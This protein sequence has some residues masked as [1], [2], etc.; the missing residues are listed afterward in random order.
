MTIVDV[1]AETAE[2]V[3]KIA[4]SAGTE[5]GEGEPVIIIIESMKIEIPVYSPKAGKVLAV[6]VKER[7]VVE[8]GTIVAGIEA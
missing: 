1:K 3:W 8:E 6:L 5:I 7:D 4:A 2:I